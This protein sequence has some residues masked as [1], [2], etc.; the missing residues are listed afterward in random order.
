[1]KNN[2]KKESKKKMIQM[3]IAIKKNWNNLLSQKTHLIPK[4]EKNYWIRL[5]MARVIKNL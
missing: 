1:M 5:L 4:Q 2:K 3:M